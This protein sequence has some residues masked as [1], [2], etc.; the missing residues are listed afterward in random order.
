MK[1]KSPTI[2]AIC[3]IAL[4]LLAGCAKIS[5]PTGGPKDTTPPKVAKMEPADGTVRF[6]GKQIRIHFDEFVTLNNP[7]ENVLIS[8]PM[9]EKPEYSTK[10]KSV[11]IK[12]KDTLRANTTYNMVFSNAIKDYHEGNSLGYLHYSFTTGD[13]LDDYMIRGN[14]L[15]AKTLAPAKDF[16][17]LLYKGDDDSLPLTTLPDYVSKSLD[18]GSFSLKNIAAGDYKLF[19]IKDINGNFRYDLPNEEIAFAE[20]TVTA[21]RAL[22]D[23]AADSLKA[24]LPLV[25]LLAFNTPDTVQRL[26]HF[27]NPAAG[28]YLFPYQTR[29]GQFSA[30]ALSQCPDHFEHINATRDTVIWYFK[31]PL[32]D[33]AIFILTADNQTDTVKLTPYK[34]KAS[35]G[36]GRTPAVKTL[37]TKFLNAGEFHRPLTLQFSYPIRPADSFNVW[38]YSQQ[39]SHKDTVVYRYAVPDTFLMEIPLPM[40]VTERKNYAVMIPDSVFFGYNGLTNDTLRAQFTTKSEKDYGTLTMNYV[41]PKN[42]KQYVA[43]LWLKEKILQEDVLTTSKTISYKFLNPDTYRVSVF[44]DENRN[45]RWDAGDYR[46]HR[47]PEKM[48]AF[49]HSISIRAYWESEET[50]QVGE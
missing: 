38:V 50:F 15:D 28:L 32:T 25:T 40:T 29:I 37:S 7:S 5:A 4:L 12:L 13:S 47:Q 45:G 10:G 26:A 16:Y 46:T 21:F 30:S 22:P 27:E 8:P 41:L 18:D 20:E 24:T 3:L 2:A 36:R 14:L 44:C 31:A 43:T 23:S 11:V 35:S 9:A 34:E 48:Y 1:P 49:P 33:T 17:V 39:Q 6:D 19:A 42:G